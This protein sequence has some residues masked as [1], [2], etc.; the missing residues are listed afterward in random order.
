MRITIVTVSC[1][2]DI[3]LSSPDSALIYGRSYES[4]GAGLHTIDH[5]FRV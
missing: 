4:L 5:I 1:H 2:A 3:L